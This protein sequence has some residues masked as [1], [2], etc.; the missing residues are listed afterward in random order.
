MSDD[1]FSRRRFLSFLAGSPLLA[2]AGIDLTTLERLRASSWRE[3]C[4]A[5]DSVQQATQDSTL[6]AAANQAVNV[7]DFEPVAR[8]KLPPAHWG[9]MATGTD[10]DATIRANREGFT[11]YALRVRRLIDVSKVN[12]SIELLGA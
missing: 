12:T 4:A 5:L 11:R 8:K 1:P 3:R 9:Y 6:I 2:A 7:F 10:D